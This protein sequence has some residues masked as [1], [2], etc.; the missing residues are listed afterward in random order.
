[1]KEWGVIMEGTREGLKLSI[2]E[3][4]TLV[5]DF[6]VVEP[7]PLFVLVALEGVLGLCVLEVVHDEHGVSG[8]CAYF[9]LALRWF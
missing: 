9:I 6:V 7:A 1:M 2:R 4:T 3:G 5:D 8:G